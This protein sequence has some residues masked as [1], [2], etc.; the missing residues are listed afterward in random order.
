MSFPSLE[1]VHLPLFKPIPEH[2]PDHERT[3]I[4]YQRAAAV[5]KIYG[6][7][8]VD[9][10]QFTQKFRNLHLD[11]IGALVCAAFTLMT[12]QI[13]L[14]GGTLARFAGKHAQY[15]NLLDQILNFDISAQY[16]LTE[17]GH[18]LDAKNLETTATMLPNGEFD[19]HT[20]KPSGAK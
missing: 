20:P 14:A 5:V 4:S 6:L 11:L 3:Y 8:A 19:L 12:I 16:L 10:L 1:L 18:G 13:N 2:T 7:T 17:V 9:V 15:R